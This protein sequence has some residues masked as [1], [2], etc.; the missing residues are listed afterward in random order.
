MATE[1][2]G[3]EGT[4]Q[5]MGNQNANAA[6][7]KNIFVLFSSFFKTFFSN[8]FFF[9]LFLERY[10]ERETSHLLVHPHKCSQWPGLGQAKVSNPEADLGLPCG[11]Q[12][13]EHL[14]VSGCPVG[15]C[16]QEIG[17]E[18]EVLRLKSNSRFRPQASPA[19]T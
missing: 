11:C 14:I 5:E 1:S 17:V 3:T 9:L 19:M 7:C 2:T 4:E 18:V 15:T 16:Y 6:N 10:R 13:P 8:F 12:G